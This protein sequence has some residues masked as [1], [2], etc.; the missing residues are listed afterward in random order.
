MENNKVDPEASITSFAW[1]NLTYEV[2][3]KGGTKALVNQLNG[4]LGPGNMLAIMGPSG[5]GKTTLLNL[6]ADRISSGKV[7]GNI[8]LNGNPRNSVSCF[9]TRVEVPELISAEQ[10]CFI[11]LTFFSADSEDMKKNQR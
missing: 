8:Y 10:R 2:K 7:S 3:A 1:E 4:Y 11:V 5:C 9:R 6:L